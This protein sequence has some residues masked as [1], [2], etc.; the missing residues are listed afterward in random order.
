MAAEIFSPVSI[1]FPIEPV[2]DLHILVVDLYAR[3]QI[4]PRRLFISTPL[5]F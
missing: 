5:D 2:Q 4:A 1:Q 3:V